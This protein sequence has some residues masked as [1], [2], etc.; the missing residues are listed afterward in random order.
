M[1]TMASERIVRAGGEAG[2]RSDFLG[3][4]CGMRVEW[5]GRDGGKDL[6]EERGVKCH[7]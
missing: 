7:C 6:F 2:E 1:S 3:E 4:E 5:N